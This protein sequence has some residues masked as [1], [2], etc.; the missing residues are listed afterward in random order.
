MWIDIVFLV[1]IIVAVVKGI[2]RGIIMAIF[3]FAGWFIGIAAAVK[4]S[5][6]VASYLQHH[7]NIGAKWLPLFAFILVFAT[8]V[9]LVQLAGK[10]VEG[11]FNISLIGWVNRLGGALL[12]TAMYTLAFSVILFY[13]EKM[14]ITGPSVIEESRAYA[15]IGGLGPSVIEAV[16]AVIPF[17]KN[18]FRE[19]E[20]FFENVAAQRSL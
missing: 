18:I 9:L 3:S 8:T 13:L 20:H 11:I 17:F 4:L 7:T 15:M 14:N 1:L 10:A 19:L 16:G 6:W 2:R 5:A 12:Y